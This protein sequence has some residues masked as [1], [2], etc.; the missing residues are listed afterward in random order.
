MRLDSNNAEYAE[1]LHHLDLLEG[2]LSPEDRAAALT[3]RRVALT[4]LAKSVRQEWLL[5]KGWSK[6]ALVIHSEY[7]Y[8]WRVQPFC[9]QRKDQKEQYMRY[10]RY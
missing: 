6:L 10:A 8:N 5:T 2:Q 1:A 4:Y 7:A 3:G 9:A